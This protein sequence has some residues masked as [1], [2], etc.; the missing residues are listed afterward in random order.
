MRT[1]SPSPRRVTLATAA[2]LIG[3]SAL[4]GG[5]GDASHA[6]AKAEGPK[7]HASVPTVHVDDL[8]SKAE[9]A[10][11]FDQW[12]MTLRTGSPHDMAAL[13]D[14]NGVLLPTVS[15]QVRSNRAEITEYFEEFQKLKPRGVINEQYI[16]V[17]DRNTA[18][19]SGV[20]TFDVVRDGRADFVVARYNFV[21]EK[22]GD[23]WLIVSHHSSAMP[24][25][26]DERPL[27]LSAQL[28]AVAKAEA[29]AAPAKAEPHGEEHADSHASAAPKK[30]DS[31]HHGGGAKDGAHH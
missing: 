21:Y 20:Y 7:S 24:Q 31:G 26:V 25:P 10:A 11:L 12:N 1:L 3:A 13:Y 2:V 23:D 29:P 19:N 14:E 15:N 30:A 8:P 16:D 4:L 28:G 27:A 9:I 6:A 22:R 5:C 18:V 17:L